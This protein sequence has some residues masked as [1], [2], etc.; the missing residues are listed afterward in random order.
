MNLEIGQLVKFGVVLEF[1]GDGI[2]IKITHGKMKIPLVNLINFSQLKNTTVL[3][4]SKL[5]IFP[6]DHWQVNTRLK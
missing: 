3:A 5:G 6:C 1:V 4:K 2:H